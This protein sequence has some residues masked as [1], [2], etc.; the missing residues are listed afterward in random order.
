MREVEKRFKLALLDLGVKD[1]INQVDSLMKKEAEF[2]LESNSYSKEHALKAYREDMRAQ[3]IMA[4]QNTDPKRAKK[5][6]VTDAG[7]L[8]R[9]QAKKECTIFWN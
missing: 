3:A 6:M 2:Y 1:N 7:E 8:Q 5:L 4:L 9:K